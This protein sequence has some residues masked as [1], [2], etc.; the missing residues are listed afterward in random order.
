MVDVKYSF[1]KSSVIQLFVYIFFGIAIIFFIGVWLWT[2]TLNPE[3]ASIANIFLPFLIIFGIIAL[4]LQIFVISKLYFVK[5]TDN[6][7]II[8]R[9][10]PTSLNYSDIKRISISGDLFKGIDTGLYMPWP[11][12]LNIDKSEEFLTEFSKRYQNNTSKRL[13]ITDNF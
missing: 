2:R 6:S 9:V 12:M 1:K 10:F 4:L 7:I 11:I 3:I 8:Y 5:L 13:I